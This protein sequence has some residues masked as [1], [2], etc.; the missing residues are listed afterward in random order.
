[1]LPLLAL[2]AAITGCG[3]S[4][5]PNTYASSAVQQANKVERGI[6]IGVRD[7]SVSA[8][9]ATGAV[10]GGAVGGIAGS[11]VGGNGVTTA[12]STLGGSL[13]GG[14]VG[15]GVE[16]ATADTKAFE[17]IVR[18]PNNELISVTQQ[19]ETALAIGQRVLVIA[20]SQAR[21]VA[22]YTVIPDEPTPE[23]PKPVV[24]ATPL[25]PVVLPAPAPLPTTLPDL[26]PAVPPAMP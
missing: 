5:S 13:V 23:P 1:M 26:P 19:D 8:S 14:L 7:V 15:S 20:G 21:I 12:L 11:Q 10:V 16:H 24:T 4:Y 22:D 18:K 3:P 25:A 6:V 17:Y 2:A 9:G